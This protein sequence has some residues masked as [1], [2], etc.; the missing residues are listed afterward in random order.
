MAAILNMAAMFDF[1]VP[2]LLDF[3]QICQI[4][5]LD[6]YLINWKHIKN[7]KKMKMLYRFKMAAK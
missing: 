1:R 3:D 2:C 4:L 5:H 6:V 7:E